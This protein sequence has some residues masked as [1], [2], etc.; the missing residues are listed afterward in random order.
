MLL[1]TFSLKQSIWREG[2]GDQDKRGNLKRWS[3]LRS[4]KSHQEVK[5]WILILSQETEVN[6]LPFSKLAEPGF[7]PPSGFFWFPFQD[8]YYYC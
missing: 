7:V 5:H 6:M 2:I 3:L 4:A 8:Y 1:D